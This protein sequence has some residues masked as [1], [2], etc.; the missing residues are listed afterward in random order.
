MGLPVITTKKCGAGVDL[1]ENKK[2]GFL[3]EADNIEELHE[4]MNYFVINICKFDSSIF[5]YNKII[6]I[7]YK[8]FSY[9]TYFNRFLK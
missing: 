9:Q 6:C 4:N 2:N 5:I 7:I 1:I 3:I 8:N